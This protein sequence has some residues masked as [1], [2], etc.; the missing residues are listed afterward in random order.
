MVNTNTMGS[1]KINNK[2]PQIYKEI[3]KLY[4]SHL[5]NL[6]ELFQ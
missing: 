2:K 1:K 3:A 5:T 4:T 6:I